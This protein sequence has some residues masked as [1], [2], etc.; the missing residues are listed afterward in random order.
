MIF[1]WRRFSFFFFS[2]FSFRFFLHFFK[3]FWGSLCCQ[4][5]FFLCHEMWFILIGTS[6]D[7]ALCE[8]GRSNYPYFLHSH[9]ASILQVFHNKIR[10]FCTSEV[11]P[12]SDYLLMPDFLYLPRLVFLLPGLPL[13]LVGHGVDLEAVESGGELLGWG[14][15]AELGVHHEEHVREAGAEVAAVRVVVLRRLWRVDLVAFR[16]VELDHRLAGD[17]RQADGQ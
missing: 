16:A 6:C 17:V 1:S 15:G 3:F 12:R 11:A 8:A 4:D 13:Q 5:F 10:F 2:D 14:F 7:V 9:Q